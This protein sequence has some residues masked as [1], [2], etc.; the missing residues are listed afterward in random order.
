MDGEPPSKAVEEDT[1]QPVQEGNSSPIVDNPPSNQIDRDFLK[2]KPPPSEADDGESIDESRDTTSRTSTRLVKFQLFETKT[3][4]LQVY[5]TD[6]SDSIS[7]D[8]IRMKRI[9]ES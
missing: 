8:P 9:I 1:P 5:Y 4:T 2:E 6:V 3:V 7:S